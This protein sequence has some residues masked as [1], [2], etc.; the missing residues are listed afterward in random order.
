MAQSART[1]AAYIYTAAGQ[2]ESTTDLA[3]DGQAL[4]CENGDLVAEAER[5]S[6]D[7]QL[8]YADI[9]LDRIVSDRARDQQLRRLDRRPPRA[10]AG[11]SARSRSSSASSDARRSRCSARSSASRTS[12]PTPS[13]RSRALLRGLQHPGPRARD[14]PARDRDREGRDRHLGRPGLHPRA[15]RRRP[16]DGPARAAARERPRLHDAGLRHVATTPRPTRGS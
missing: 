7:E 8:L 14:A 11:A 6:L 16:R 15:D 3:W 2:G 12:R 9:D 5:F 10:P 1:I 13:T 4:I